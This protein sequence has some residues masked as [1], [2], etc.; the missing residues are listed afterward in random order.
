M[1]WNRESVMDQKINLVAEWQSGLYSK[2]QL[3]SR[4]GLSRPTL[5][6]WLCRYA[7]QGVEGLKEAS[8]RPFSCP[9]QVSEPIIQ[10]LLEQKNQHPTWG[11]KKLVIMLQREHPDL[12]VPA[13]S[14]AGEWLRKLGLVKTRRRFNRPP[15]GPKTMRPA[16]EPNQ[17][18]AADFKGSFKLKGGL[19]CHPLTITDHASRFLLLCKAQ[20]DVSNAREGFERA[21]YEFGLPDVIRTDNGSP[22]ASTGFSRLST[23][24]VWWIRLGIYPE[25]IQLGRPDQNGRHERMHRTLKD[26]L[27]NAPEAS[28]IQQQLAFERF[29]EEFNHVRPHEALE[30]KTPAH[31][32]IPSAR[33]YHGAV[34]P[35]EYSPEMV[36]RRVRLNGHI[37]WKGKSLFMSEA[38]VGET[39]GMQEVDEEVW[40]LYLC[41]HR[42][43]R[44]ER[45]AKRFSSL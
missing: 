11:P 13:P 34:P 20:L 43:G 33:E 42:L 37:K 19:R 8:R 9:T 21:F 12:M 31:L 44:L 17:T 39:I 18:W 45:G 38:L 7:E 15:K 5:D 29:R 36:V 41:H 24:S 28:L 26:D 30:M 10:L 2:T 14:T 22:F 27:L 4:H 32:Y 3:A 23:L 6:K 35:F 1:P 25:L 40:D 16:E